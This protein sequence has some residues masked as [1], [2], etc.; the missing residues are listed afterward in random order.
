[1]IDG[2]PQQ[3]S[4]LIMSLSF[5]D[6]SHFSGRDYIQ[7]NDYIDILL[8]RIVEYEE[9]YIHTRKIP[10][11]FI[12]QVIKLIEYYNIYQYKS[13]I[14]LEKLLYIIFYYIQ[15][16]NNIIKLFD[17]TYGPEAYYKLKNVSDN[18]DVLKPTTKNFMNMII[19]DIENHIKESRKYAY[20][21]LDKE[22]SNLPH[23]VVKI[24]VNYIPHKQILN[25]S[26]IF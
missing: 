8:S 13:E 3:F 4:N 24:I 14:I 20:K 25:I 26:K 23:V 21:V 22:L 9:V 17:K 1:M 7:T 5:I 6:V 2:L 18:L 10:T 12:Y 19:Y 15:Q 11:F 16:R